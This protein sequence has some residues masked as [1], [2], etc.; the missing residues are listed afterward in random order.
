MKAQII[1]DPKET[2]SPKAIHCPACGAKAFYTLGEVAA[3]GERCRICNTYFS[4]T[5][6]EE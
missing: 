3:F 4:V 6:K 5:W 2:E 1:V